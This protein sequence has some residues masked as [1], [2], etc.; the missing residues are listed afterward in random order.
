[1]LSINIE[2]NGCSMHVGANKVVVGSKPLYK[3][4]TYILQLLTSPICSNIE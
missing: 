4:I 2:N 1:M 3:Q